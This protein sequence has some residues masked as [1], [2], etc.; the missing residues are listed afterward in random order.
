L[1]GSYAINIFSE[2]PD[3]RLTNKKVS[4]TLSEIINSVCRN[5]FKNEPRQNRI[6]FSQIIKLAGR[7]NLWGMEKKNI[8]AKL[9][10]CSCNV[11]RT[12]Y[13]YIEYYQFSA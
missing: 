8:A 1:L 12:P 4:L 7:Q 13:L 6:D 10:M 2:I 11:V 5:L 3:G 9:M